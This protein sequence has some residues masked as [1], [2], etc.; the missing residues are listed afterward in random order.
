[1]KMRFCPV[2]W[3]TDETF[4]AGGEEL[5]DS[6]LNLKEKLVVI[7]KSDL[8]SLIASAKTQRLHA[9]PQCDGSGGVDSG[10][11]SPWGAAITLPCPACNPQKDQ[12]P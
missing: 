11:F 8:E 6:E 2:K 12:Q 10:G 9:C 4:V 5:Y 1:M 3:I 7:A